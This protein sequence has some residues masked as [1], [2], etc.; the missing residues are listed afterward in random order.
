MTLGDTLQLFLVLFSA[1]DFCIN[2]AKF[3]VDVIK[4]AKKNNRL[5]PG[6]LAIIRLIYNNCEHH[7][8]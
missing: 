8:L 5:S 2:I 3:I 7:R 6:Q 1:G 4:I